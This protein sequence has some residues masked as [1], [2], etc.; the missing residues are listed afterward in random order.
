MASSSSC[1]SSPITLEPIPTVTSISPCTSMTSLGAATTVTNNTNEEDAIISTAN[2]DDT[3]K[4]NHPQQ[5]DEP[6]KW[7]VRIMRALVTPPRRLR[8]RPILMQSSSIEPKEH[9]VKEEEEEEEVEEPWYMRAPIPAT[10]PLKITW[11]I[12]TILLSLTVGAYTTH[13]AIRDRNFLHHFHDM[14]NN[15]DYEQDHH[16]H[17]HQS[18]NVHTHHTANHHNAIPE[19]SGGQHSHS[20]SD[21]VMFA[22]LLLFNIQIPLNLLHITIHNTKYNIVAIFI[23]CWFTIDMILNFF[24]EHTLRDGRVIRQGRAVKMRYLTTWFAVDALSLVPW[25]RVLVQPIIEMQNRR[26]IF[27]KTFVRSK[28]VLRVTP[29]VL[30]NLRKTNLLMFGRVAKQTGWG[31]RGLIQ[32]MI[33]YIPKYLMFYRNMKGALAIRLLRQ[34]HWFRKIWKLFTTKVDLKYNKLKC[35]SEMKRAN[36]VLS[37]ASKKLKLDSLYHVVGGSSLTLLGRDDDLKI[38]LSA[39]PAFCADDN[40]DD[41]KGEV[42]VVLIVDDD[43]SCGY[44][45]GDEVSACHEEE[46]YEVDVT[47]AGS[48]GDVG[49]KYEERVCPDELENNANLANGVS[50]SITMTTNPQRSLKPLPKSSSTLRRRRINSRVLTIVDE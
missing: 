3:M 50:L 40:D 19:H 11:D 6:Q 36:A 46:E 16:H 8:H 13:A 23:E 4:Q 18:S 2:D 28:A 34:I 10:H 25:E 20:N 37:S 45:D 29:K 49:S 17:A 26:N 15:N 1:P 48:N 35:A 22:T 44:Y 12:L 21:D 9:N 31:S 43:C 30:R 42:E 32:K 5:D 47:T 39:L 7:R 14:G 41:E 27:K 33:K 24:T 38:S